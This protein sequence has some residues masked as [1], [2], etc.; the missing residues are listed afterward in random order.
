M[1]T[2]AAEEEIKVIKPGTAGLFSYLG[3][4]WKYRV[5]IYTFARQELKVQYSQTALGFAW[6][7]LRPLMV[8]M[9]F[10]FIFSQ[11][12][13]IKNL[14]VPYPLFAFSGL[15]AWNYFSY[16]VSNAGNAVIAGQQ[17]I[18][19]VYFPKIILLLSK[20][21]VGLVEFAI[22]FVLMLIIGM[23]MG[24]RPTWTIIYLP[25]FIV[26][27]LFMGLT[28]AIWLNALNV[29]FRDINQFV[30]QLIGFLIWLTPVFYP[31]TMIPEKYSVVLY[32]NP[33]AGIIQGYRDCILAERWPLQPYFPAFAVVA[34]VMVVG[35]LVFIK[36]EDEMA[37]YL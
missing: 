13:P 12:I 7:I 31:G 23:F 32:A 2:S 8:V 20:S 26:M 5:L 21:L 15:I 25:I 33:L 27:N 28:V 10:T 14:G 36:A 16:V 17:L 1:V 24:Y 9:V 18:R 22:S 35:L 30:P 19:K 11:V 29:R 34:A 37:D 3:E 4:V 6:A